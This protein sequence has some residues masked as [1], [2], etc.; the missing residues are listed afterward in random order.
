MSSLYTW[1]TKTD[2]GAIFYDF[3]TTGLNQYHDKITEFCFITNDGN[4][5]TS[6]IDPEVNI[7][8][9]IQ[10]ITKITNELVSGK[11][12][13]WQEIPN[14]VSF[15]E[16]SYRF[17]Y[18][19]AH[20]GDNFDKIFHQTQLKKYD[21]NCNNYSWKYIDTLLLAKKLLPHQKRYSLKSLLLYFEIDLENSHR[22]EDDT[23]ALQSLYTELCKLISNEITI[24]YEELIS[25]PSIVY[26]YLY[27]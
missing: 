9:K 26:N 21:Q 27:L 1:L 25:T 23:L 5:I 15:I 22:A 19:I 20:N 17:N 12:K 4:K 2:E 11:P 14:I 7:S 13:I 3:E 8:E 18:L 6:L 10:K 24:S 16:K